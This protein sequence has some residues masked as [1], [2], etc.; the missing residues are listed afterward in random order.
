MQE[1]AGGKWF[2]FHVAFNV[3]PPKFNLLNSIEYFFL[4]TKKWQ[5]IYPETMGKHTEET[6]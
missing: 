6:Y 4:F 2:R 3:N 1:Y 5:I